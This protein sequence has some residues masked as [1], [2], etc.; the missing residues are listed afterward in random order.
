MG[1]NRSDAILHPRI[2]RKTSRQFGQNEWPWDL[3]AGRSEIGPYLQVKTVTL[4]W[5]LPEC[6]A[7]CLH[8]A[9]ERTGEQS[10]SQ[11][12]FCAFL[13]QYLR[14]FEAVE[15]APPKP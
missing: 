9:Y 8:R 4:L 7:G 12:N 3:R 14:G 5:K 13:G 2:R 6:Y 11:R 15:F 1:H 10:R